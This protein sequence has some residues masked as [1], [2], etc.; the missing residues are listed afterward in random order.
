MNDVLL[1]STFLFSYILLSLT[2]SNRPCIQ[3]TPILKFS[4]VNPHQLRQRANFN[5]QGTR[6]LSSELEQRLNDSSTTLFEDETK[7]LFGITW[8]GDM[9]ANMEHIQRREISDILVPS[10]SCLLH[11]AIADLLGQP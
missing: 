10:T 8:T 7:F 11:L 1:P 4:K 2:G 5:N 9:V 6:C 3:R